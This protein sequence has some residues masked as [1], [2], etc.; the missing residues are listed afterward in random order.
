MQKIS[1][2]CHIHFTITCKR[3][4]DSC[5]QYVCFSFFIKFAKNISEVIRKQNNEFE[6]YKYIVNE[7]I[8]IRILEIFNEDFN[9]NK[10]K[11][12]VKLRR[13]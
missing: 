13:F 2:I 9:K 10:E 3:E 5:N 12:C 8:T 6:K 7:F 11:I 1:S 4:I